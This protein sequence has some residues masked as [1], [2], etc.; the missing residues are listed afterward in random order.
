[1]AEGSDPVAEAELKEGVAR[2]LFS[3]MTLERG[4]YLLLLASA[5]ALRLYALE[6]RPLSSEEA[7]LAYRA[8][9]FYQGSGGSVAGGSPLLFHGSLISYLILGASDFSTRLFPALVGSALVGLPYLLRAHL[10]RVGALVA[11]TLLAF[12]PSFLFFSRYLGGEAMVIAGAL[13]FLAGLLHYRDKGDLRALY[14]AAGG[15]ALS[16]TAGSEAFSLLLICLGFLPLALLAS[17]GKDFPSSS[18]SLR[19]LAFFALIFLLLSTGGLVNPGGL[20]AALDL[21]PAWLSRWS[22]RGPWWHPLFLLLAY[23][24]LPLVLGLVGAPFLWRRDRLAAFLAF[25]VGWGLLLYAFRG[26]YPGSSLYLSLPLILLSGLLID[27][28]V[29]DSGT[30]S[31]TKEGLY[32]ALSLPVLIYLFLQLALY[33]ERG[34]REQI[35]LA[36]MALSFLAILSLF[37]YGWFGP[38]VAARGAMLLLL[39]A[40]GAVNFSQGWRLNYQAQPS[41]EPLLTEATSPDLRNLV[42]A[43]ETLSN[44][45]EGERQAIAIT[46]TEGDPALAWHLRGFKDLTFARSGDPLP[47]TAVIIASLEEELALP[48]YRG[49]RF[50][51]SSSWRLGGWDGAGFLRWYLYRQ[52]DGSSQSRD[53]I[54]W[55]SW[56]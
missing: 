9:R 54:M 10:G 50:R 6:R 47:P 14:L 22:A 55:V 48:G 11:S 25:W 43:L 28:L 19:V 24:P 7:D 39:L 21:F 23:E 51:L 35:L 44:Q 49:E 1:M 16:L 17:K 2:P 30:L 52:D 31:W 26:G 46:V 13:A 33:S 5:L 3:S 53:I 45:R 32:L 8:W 38:R 15:S 56:P 20:Q 34:E 4:L 41:A 12:S 18:I 29:H 27:G 42:D 40:L 36:F 37:F